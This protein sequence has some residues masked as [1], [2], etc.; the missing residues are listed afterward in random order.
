MKDFCSSALDVSSLDAPE[1]VVG[2]VVRH[3]VVV[4][5]AGSSSRFNA[6]FMKGRLD[7][8]SVK[9][10]FLSFEGLPVL[11]RAV[12]PFLDVPGLS[13]VVV[14]YKAGCL[15]ETRSSL[16]SLVPLLDGAGVPLYFVEGGDT[17]Q[18]SVFNALSFLKRLWDDGAGFDLVSIHD[19]ARPFV[20]KDV[21]F[22]CLDAA[23]KCGG[24]APCVPVR[25]TLVRISDGFLSGRL[26]RDGVCGVQTPQTFRFP[27]IYKAHVKARDLVDGVGKVGSAFTDD[28]QIFMKFGGLV[29]AVKGSPKNVKIT[30]RDDLEGGI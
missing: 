24:A 30:Y 23:F 8:G 6:G 4:T 19:G 15:E 22:A 1:R 10:E 13:V 2:H 20:S 18:S 28:T 12:K 3:A 7:S 14:T 5:A 9:K 27:E 11:A 29:A 26:D 17:R 16:E 25:D 21:V